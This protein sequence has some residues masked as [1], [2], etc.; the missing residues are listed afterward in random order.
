MWEGLSGWKGSGS[1]AE[2]EFFLGLEQFWWAGAKAME[3]IHKG[4]FGSD[5]KQ[6]SGSRA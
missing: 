1:T 3:V 4:G 2:V 5:R 6:G